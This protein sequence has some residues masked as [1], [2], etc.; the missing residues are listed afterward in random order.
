MGMR[1]RKT[2]KDSGRK[3]IAQES[4]R[5]DGRLGR[6]G[7]CAFAG[8]VAACLLWF[9]AAR[10]NGYRALGEPEC[11]TSAEPM[12]QA[13]A[14]AAEIRRDILALADACVLC[15]Q[16]LPVCPTY[17]L[18]QR[19]AESPRGR[20]VIVQHLARASHG[21]LGADLP[22][23]DHC[24]SCGRCEAICP[25]KVEFSRLMDLSRQLRF[26]GRSSPLAV[27]GI[28]AVV[29][30]PT[31][32]GWLIRLTAWPVQWLPG[33]WMRI[34]RA[35]R[36]PLTVFTPSLVSD[37][38]PAVILFA[39]C[40][41]RYAEQTA[42]IA[43]RRIL[44]RL[45][46]QV[47]EMPSQGCCGAL[48]RHAGD[49]AVAARMAQTN[50]RA[51]AAALASHTVQPRYILTLSTGC[52][53]DVAN[54]LGQRLPV[55]EAMEFLLS[56]TRLREWQFRS[57]AAEVV[58]HSPCTS[59]S[60]VENGLWAAE[61]IL[62]LL[63]GLRVQ[64]MPRQGCCGAAGAHMLA[65]PQRAALLAASVLDQFASFPEARRCTSNV[66]CHLH[67]QTLSDPSTPQLQHPLVLID[68]AM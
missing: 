37:S 8:E 42:L 28:L 56:H 62:R 31:L 66:G 64:L 68:E 14:P 49:A 45:G 53:S 21:E 44:E 3:F 60:T 51:L 18:D 26:P 10:A 24:L 13:N 36:A 6:S 12:S 43:L 39:G 55:L 40:V 38:R 63:P 29:T 20:I 2:A 47:V 65:F 27:R 23:L 1:E 35:L 54:T 4:C 22:A 5:L 30:R 19:E 59:R 46:W 50:Q 25:A 58:L 34:A 61:E 32:L 33:R 41:E 67:L 52:H 15:G 57:V 7:C 9:G 16:C 48:A 17:A 11:Q